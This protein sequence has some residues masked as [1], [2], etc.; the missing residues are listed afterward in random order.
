MIVY[1]LKEI[2]WFD[3]FDGDLKW[4]EDDRFIVGRGSLFIVYFGVFFCKEEKEI[5]EIEVV[6]RVYIDFFLKENVG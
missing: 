1:V 2:R 5:K 4:I 3:F 6:L